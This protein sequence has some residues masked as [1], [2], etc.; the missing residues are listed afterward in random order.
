[1]HIANAVCPKCKAGF[2]VDQK[3]WNVGT[4]KLRCIGC[5]HEFLPPSSPKSSSVE[6][7]ANA[8]VPIRVWETG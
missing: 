3:L 4:V 1:M 6:E 8:A 5:K 2:I 7:A